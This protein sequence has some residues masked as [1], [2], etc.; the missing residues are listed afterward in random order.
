MNALLLKIR[1]VYGQERIYPVNE[2]AKIFADIANTK[3]LSRNVIASAR[4]LGFE[5]KTVSN[6]V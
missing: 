4:E 5:I 3:T 6:E 1:E 2:I